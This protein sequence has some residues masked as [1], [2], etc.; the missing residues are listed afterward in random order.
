V[1]RVECAF[2]ATVPRDEYLLKIDEAIAS[3]TAKLKAYLADMQ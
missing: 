1:W 3:A 2:H